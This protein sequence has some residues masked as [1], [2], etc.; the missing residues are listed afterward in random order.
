[1]FLIKLKHC[2]SQLNIQKE[3][4]SCKKLEPSQSKSPQPP[5]P[6]QFHGNELFK[7]SCQ[8]FPPLIRPVAPR[9]FVLKKHILSEVMYFGHQNTHQHFTKA[10]TLSTLRPSPHQQSVQ[11]R[12][13]GSTEHAQNPC[14]RDCFTPWT[15]C[16]FW[17]EFHPIG[18]LLGEG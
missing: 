18:A 16:F 10:A 4:K 14:H 2:S 17:L 1:M 12:R 7:L 5:H 15:E 11:S 13:R 8:P 3:L 6:S 9:P